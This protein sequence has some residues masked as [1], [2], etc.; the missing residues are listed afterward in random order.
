MAMLYDATTEE[1]VRRFWSRCEKPKGYPRELGALVPI[2]L[3]LAVATI[4]P[5]TLFSIEQWLSRRGAAFSFGCRSRFVR[6]CLVA[7][8]GSG[9]IFVDTSDPEDERR[10]TIAHEAAHFLDYLLARESAV[11]RFGQQITEVL[12]GKRAP[13]PFERFGAIISHTSIRFFTDLMERDDLDVQEKDGVWEVEDRADQIALA[14]LAPSEDVLA[15]TSP[16][17]ELFAERCQQIKKTLRSTFGLPASI[18]AGYALAILEEIG[19]GPSWA[20]N[21]KIMRL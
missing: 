9:I 20:E 8:S 12:D 3:P 15:S 17:A 10:F 4:S 5:L 6:G 11:A 21:L 13:R 14:L 16:L 19:R 2:T 7:A 18:A 1:A